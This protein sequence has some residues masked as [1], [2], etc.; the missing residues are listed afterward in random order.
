MSSDKLHIG[1]LLTS[2]AGGGAERNILRLAQSLIERGHRADLVIPSFAGDYLAAIPGGMRVYRARIPGTDRKFLQAVQRLGVHVEAMTVN[3][4]GAA[5]TWL[6]LAR[7]YP[8]IPVLRGSGMRSIYPYAHFLARY[9]REVRP[10]VLV[11]ALPGPNTVAVCAAELTNRVVPVVVTVRT[12]VAADYAPEWLEA[13]RTLYPLADA[14]VAVSKGAAES[15]RRSLRVDAERV[16]TIYNGVPAGRIRRLA[17]AEV[18]HPWFAD[19]EPPVIL[20]VGRESPPKD[21]PTLVEAFGLAR[22]EVDA[23]LVILGRL[24]ARYRARLKFLAQRYGVEGDIGFVDFDENPYRYMRRAGLLALSSRWEG[25]PG[26]ILEALACGTP[27]VS[28]DTPYGPREILGDWGDL[29][30][31]GDA[32]ALARALVTTLRGERPMVEALQVRAADFSSEKAADAYV[33]LFE[34]L[35]RERHA[36]SSD[37]L[38]VGF[39]LTGLHGG[40]A[41]RVMLNLAAALIARGHRADLVIPKLE[42]DYRAAI[43]LG[44]RVYRARIPGINRKFLRAVQRAG[45]QVEAMTVN[46]IKAARTWLVLARR[47]PAIPVIRGSGMRSIYPCAHFL[48]QYTREVRPHVLISGLPGPNTIAVCAAELMDRAVPVVTTVWNNV[49]ADYTPEWLEA[50]RTLY[51]LADAVVAVS[52][53]VAESVRRSLGVGA[54]RV[55]TI[56][57]PIPADSI[58]RLAQEEITHPWFADGEPPVVL[59]VGREAP[60]KDHSTLVE[61]FGLARRE[62]DSRLVILGKLS[63][64]YRARLRSLARSLGVEGD[65]GF[66]GFDENPYR[67]MRRAGLLALSSRWEGLPM[68]ILEALACGTPVVSTDA[69]YGPREILGGW[70]D[71]PPVGDAPALARALVATLRG[72]RPA[73]EALRARAADFSIEKAT[74]AY[75]ALFEKLV[76]ARAR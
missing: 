2:L 72:A 4:I 18:A 57:S 37:K 38:H 47:Y 39:L 48:A 69:P 29:P 63:A 36:V 70:G 41:E 12:N 50:S 68:V 45:V 19:N 76:R 22:R 6:V 8:G 40:G 10:H 15:V 74:D 42:G 64:P 7:K 24:S 13:A 16:C 21:H 28:T 60:Q 26:V 1:F 17:Q 54:E 43:P 33:A 46:P 71:L 23:R 44:M 9:I 66:V 53:G 73:E 49:T 27:V 30:P 61:A 59:S 51:P 20:S 31:V 34:K 14:V 3:P 56:H 75:V 67:Y 11:S 62:V 55:R 65:L 25:L 5:R 58:R 32:P 35:A 52:K